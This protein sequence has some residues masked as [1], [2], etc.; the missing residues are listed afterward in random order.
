MLHVNTN[1]DSKLNFGMGNGF[2]LFLHNAKESF[3][4]NPLPFVNSD[5]DPFLPLGKDAVIDLKRPIKTLNTIFI[6]LGW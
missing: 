6:R 4:L 1:I 3:T 5:S 2:D